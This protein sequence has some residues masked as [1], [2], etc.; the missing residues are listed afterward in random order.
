MSKP[1]YF[2]V[3]NMKTPTLRR[4]IAWL[5]MSTFILTQASQVAALTLAA[6]PLAATTTATVRPNIMYVLD[7]SG[8]MAWDFTPDYINDGTVAADPGSL[9]GSLGDG[10]VAT[11]SGGHVNSINP[12]SNGYNHTYTSA[13]AVVIDGGGGT[14]A[15][16]V[17]NF[18][19]TT[20][21]I[22]S[23]TVTN[24]GT[25]YTSVPY[26]TLVGGLNN[27]TWGMCWG[28]TGASNLGGVP[29]DT[30]VSPTCTGT[31]QVPYATGGINYQF[32]DPAV[33][34]DA[35]FKADGTR[36]ANSTPT[37]A[38]QDGFSAS[39]ASTNLTTTWAHEVW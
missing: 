29:K 27:A 1:E 19:N 25:G 31:T 14:G 37:A 23:V 9:G 13:P 8:S 3:I 6:S 15:Q 20:K 24:T 30:T 21:R 38:K 26:V 33:R 35:P 39:G 16:A 17:A 32:Y 11:V 12:D 34:Y 2:E 28:T 10:V 22:T 7:D 5:V 4:S 36:Y 18:N